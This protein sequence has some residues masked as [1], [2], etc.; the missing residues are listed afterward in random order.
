MSI[1]LELIAKYLTDLDL[2]FER[3]KDDQIRTGFSSEEGEDIATIFALDEE[4][5]YLKITCWSKENLK[6][7]SSNDLVR[8]EI[9]KW[10]LHQNYRIKTGNWE[11]NS[12]E[13]D[14]HFAIEV[15]IEDGDLTFKQF[16]RFI[17][18]IFSVSKDMAALKQLIQGM[19]FEQVVELEDKNTKEALKEKLESMLRTLEETGDTSDLGA[20][21]GI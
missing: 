1:Q 16:S 8:A 2:G 12:V 4:G 6:I 5:E 7:E 10:M 21:N 18:V 13:H 20:L 11:Y 9:Y 19:S 3:V 17:S 15:A 14:S